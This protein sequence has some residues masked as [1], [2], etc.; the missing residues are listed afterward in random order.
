M[1]K[2]VVYKGIKYWLQQSG[3]YYSCGVKDSKPRLLHR[4]IWTDHFGSIPKGFVVHH[5]DHNWKN[6]DISNLELM[7]MKKHLS[8]HAK[9][10]YKKPD[11]VRKI[12]RA[13]VKAQKAAKEWHGSKEGIK[14]HRKHA[15]E[16]WQ[17]RKKETITCS[18]CGKKAERYFAARKN[19]RFCSRSCSQKEAYKKHF[20]DKRTCLICKKKFMAN[21]HRETATCSRS[22]G[23]KMRWNS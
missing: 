14:W 7:E 17:D 23:A 13:L 12:K 11:Y 18:V 4:K 10:S 1:K 15:K 3:R 5:K 22:C 20:T 8:D 19:T 6:N 2:F 16:G 9:E 21:R